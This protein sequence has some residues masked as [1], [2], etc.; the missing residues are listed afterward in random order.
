MRTQKLTEFDR[1]YQTIEFKDKYLICINDDTFDSPRVLHSLLLSEQFNVM[2]R[3][4][5]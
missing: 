2:L 1:L 3:T 5:G 4:V